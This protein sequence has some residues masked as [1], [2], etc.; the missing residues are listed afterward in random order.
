MALSN[1]SIGAMHISAEIYC[2]DA[3]EPQEARYALEAGAMQVVELGRSAEGERPGTSCPASA[4]SR[5]L[6]K[7]DGPPGTMGMVLLNRS[8]SGPLFFSKVVNAKKF[9]GDSFILPYFDTG[10]D[11]NGAFTLANRTPQPQTIAVEVLP[12]AGDFA[13]YREI[14]SITLKP[15]EVVH[16]TTKRLL[17]ANSASSG[18]VALRFRLPNSTNAISD[19]PF[20]VDLVQRNRKLGIFLHSEPK[21]PETDRSAGFS[22]P[23]QVGGGAETIIALMN[24]SLTDEV[25][26]MA[27]VH[28]GAT[29]LSS[30]SEHPLK[31]LEVKY[32]RLSD[33]LAADPDVAAQIDAESKPDQTLSGFIQ[34][35]VQP[36]V[37]QRRFLLSQSV[38]M[39]GRQG[40]GMVSSCMTCPPSAWG[41]SVS[42]LSFVG[43]VG[44]TFPLTPVCH[45]DNGTQQTIM[46]PFVLSWSPATSGIA[47]VTS[48]WSSNTLSLLGPG[49]TT[50]GS[51]ANDCVYEYDHSLDECNCFGTPFDVQQ[52]MQVT[53]T[54]FF[55]L[56]PDPENQYIN[57]TNGRVRFKLS[58]TTCPVGGSVT[59]GITP[60]PNGGLSNFVY[61][62]SN[63]INVSLP[64]PGNPTPWQNID[65]SL[66]G[67]GSVYFEVR[68]VA[69]AGEDCTTKKWSVTP[70]VRNTNAVN[71][72]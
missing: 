62:P 18:P 51:Q 4:P 61:D 64:A 15:Y 5:L 49:T 11:W 33:L 41:Y 2:G 47:S 38:I 22:Q 63:T 48:T 52:T 10:S 8:R 21:N 9:R 58:N 44:Q 69:C 72:P 30:M 26:W 35:S 12:E 29:K 71:F 70:V 45:L 50:I 40:M 54:C 37:G 14:E 27:T 43:N 42:P 34:V 20:L 19:S 55:T 6:L 23:W 25:P 67:Q 53:S 17:P 7:H 28:V 68:V 59:V 32:L 65:Y 1:T 56:V 16:Q 57:A 66:S 13:S 31:P 46:N 3:S 36:N 60:I 24:P 39:D